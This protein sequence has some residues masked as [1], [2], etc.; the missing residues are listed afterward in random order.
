MR[1]HGMKNNHEGQSTSMLSTRIGALGA[2]P[3][4]ISWLYKGIADRR[5][6]S[7]ARF[8]VRVSAIGLSP[9]HGSPPCDLLSAHATESDESP[10][11]YL[12]EELLGGPTELRAPTAER[13]ALFLDAALAS[14]SQ[15]QQQNQQSSGQDPALL[16]TLHVYQYS[17]AGKGGVAGGRSRLHLIDLGSCAGRGSR[18]PLSGLSNVLLAVLSGQRHPPHRDHP[19]TPLLRDCLQPLSCRVT[20]LAHVAHSQCHSDALTTVQI[21]SRVHRMRRRRVLKQVNCTTSDDH[22]QQSEP[23]P[24]SSDLSAD[25]VIYLGPVDE[26]TDGEHPPVYLPGINSGDNRC[27]MGKALRGSGAEIKLSRLPPTHK[28]VTSSP[29]KSSPAKKNVQKEQ[30]LSSPARSSHKGSEEQWIDGPRVSKSK[31]AEARCMMKLHSD[32]IKQHETW[33]DGPAIK[34]PVTHSTGGYGFMDSHKKSMIRQWVQNSTSQLQSKRTPTR[35]YLPTPTSLPIANHEEMLEIEVTEKKTKIE[36]SVVKTGLREMKPSDAI[37]E[38]VDEEDSSEEGP[39]EI[40][41]ALELIR[42]LST[43]SLNVCNTQDSCLQVTEDD[44]ARCMSVKDHPL[45]A[46]SFSDVTAVSSFNGIYDTFS[47]CDIDENSRRHF[48]QLAKL[49]EL[50]Q[51]Q[52]AMAEVTPHY[53]ASSVYSEPVYR[54]ADGNGS[55]YSEPA[56]RMYGKSESKPDLV[57]DLNMANEL[58]NLRQPDGASDPN[59]NEDLSLPIV[60]LVSVDAPDVICSSSAIIVPVQQQEL[61]D[62]GH[63]STPRASKHSGI[64]RRAESGYD[65]VASSSVVNANMSY[66]KTPKNT[67]VKCK[68]QG[69]NKS[70]CSWLRNPFTCANP[71]TDAEVSDF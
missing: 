50:F 60:S 16:F 54:R 67:K 53:G 59:I 35:S 10:G 11:V 24:S 49:R 9:A 37:N 15:H 55:V 63:E 45:S 8:S 38:Q 5:Q 17:L 71:E 65:S 70:F 31:V 28:K 33:I 6:R 47:E 18:L 57:I 1:W 69:D 26:A 32:Q 44:I 36:E 21:A 48:D 41:P 29:A 40:P 58:C 23:D 7:G 43:D 12:R 19:L 34:L 62:S 3:C 61:Y 51:S 14:R 39:S 66:H 42:P 22:K 20:V 64:S 4:A 46:L 30:V 13:A 2:I 56:Y 68:Y 25:T 52:L 27:A